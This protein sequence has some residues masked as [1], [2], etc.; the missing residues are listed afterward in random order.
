MFLTHTLA[1]FVGNVTQQERNELM[2][3]QG[4]TIWLTGLSASGKVSQHVLT[5]ANVSFVPSY[6][7]ASKRS[8]FLILFSLPLHQRWNSTYC[9]RS[10]MPS[11][12]MVT[13]CDSA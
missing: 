7:D 6:A 9:T 11:D 4:A 1:T 3:Q 5:K 10:Y 12:W 2:G 13:M 8:C